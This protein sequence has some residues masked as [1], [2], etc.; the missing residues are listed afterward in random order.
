MP[1]EPI[2]SRTFS[3]HLL[4]LSALVVVGMMCLAAARSAGQNRK[5]TSPS[6]TVLARF[7]ASSTSQLTYE[8]SLGKC[9]KAACPIQVRLLEGKLVYGVA[10]LD[11][12]ATPAQPVRAQA[13][14][15]LG[16]GDPLHAESGLAAWEVGN[17]TRNVSVAA[18]TI[19]LT[20]QLK[21]LL[22]HQRAGFEH[23][24]RRHYLF[25]AIGRKL[26]RV[27]TG[28]EGEGPTWSTVAL[29]EPQGD[30]AQQLIF[31][32]GFRYPS[33]DEPDSLEVTTFRWNQNK[34]VMEAEPAAE[35]KSPVTAL[36]VGVYDTAAKAREAYRQRPECLKDFWVLTADSFPQIPAGKVGI[37][38]FSA[39]EAFAR[40]TDKAVQ[41][42]APAL[43]SQF[44]QWRP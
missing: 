32:S 4:F 25:V 38:A 9:L 42:C 11:W 37:V 44:Y 6:G 17:E 24:K 1:S 13:D 16:A 35:R 34:K 22:V 19:S 23:L 2:R 15:S 39:R 10:T 33:D 5:T 26:A 30:G 31:F 27:W 43:K 40:Q 28:E 21:G 8:L 14:A 29:T 3:G 7:P 20:P 36:V 12:R 18:Q 41:A